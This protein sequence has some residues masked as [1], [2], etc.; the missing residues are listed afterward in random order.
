[1][2]VAMPCDALSTPTPNSVFEQQIYL[3]EVSRRLL[4]ASSLDA[5]HLGTRVDLIRADHPATNGD[6]Q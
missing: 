5:P 3:F 2:N 4:P 1:M 6:L